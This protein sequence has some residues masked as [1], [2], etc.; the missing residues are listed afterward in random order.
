MTKINR[1]FNGNEKRVKITQNY[2][3]IISFSVTLN[4]FN[5]INQMNVRIIFSLKMFMNAKHKY[6]TKFTQFLLFLCEVNYG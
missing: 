5:P 4:Y 6:L 2:Q 1:F 3:M